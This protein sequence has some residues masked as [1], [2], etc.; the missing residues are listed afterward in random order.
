MSVLQGCINVVLMHAE[1]IDKLI[2]KKKFDIIKKIIVYMHMYRCQICIYV[3][4][5]IYMYMYIHTML[6]H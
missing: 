1:D 3:Y 6:N 5:Y 4:I 2:E